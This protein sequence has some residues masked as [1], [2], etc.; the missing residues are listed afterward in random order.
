MSKDPVMFLKDNK[1][2]SNTE[3]A[4]TYTTGCSDVN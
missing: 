4:W 3:D 1:L 2:Y